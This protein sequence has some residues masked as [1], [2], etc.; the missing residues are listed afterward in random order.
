MNA[1]ATGLKAA[2]AGATGYVGGELLRLLVD[3]PRVSHLVAEIDVGASIADEGNPLRAL[4][5]VT[6]L[7][8]ALLLADFV[9]ILFHLNAAVNDLQ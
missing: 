9:E 8:G 4:T 3:H 6:D 5:R 1:A 7:G 2:V